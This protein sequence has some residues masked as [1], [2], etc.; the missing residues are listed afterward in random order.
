MSVIY[1]WNSFVLWF[2]NSDLKEHFVVEFKEWQQTRLNALGLIMN[3]IIQVDI[4]VALFWL[5]F[6]KTLGEGK[7]WLLEMV[8][9]HPF[10]E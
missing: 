10:Q 2:C 7:I 4:V 8:Y 6:A 9:H 3:I 1:I 5:E